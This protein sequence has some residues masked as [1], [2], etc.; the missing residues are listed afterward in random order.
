MST[1]GLG[2]VGLGPGQNAQDVTSFNF[3][4][5]QIYDDLIYTHG[6]HTL[7][8]GGSIEYDQ[9]NYDSPNQHSGVWNFGSLEDFYTGNATSFGAQI[10]GEP[11]ER[12]ARQRIFGVYAQDDIRLRRNLTVNLGLRYERATSPGEVD[13]KLADLRNITDPTSTIGSLYVPSSLN[14]SPRIGLAWDPFGNGKTSVRAAFGIYDALPLLYEMANRFNRGYPFYQQGLINWCGDAVS[15]PQNPCTPAPAGVF[16]KGGLAALQSVPSIVTVS[17]EHNPHRSYLTQWNLNVQRDLGHGLMAQLGYVG[18]RGTHLANGDYDINTYVPQMTAQGPFWDP[19]LPAQQPGKPCPSPTRNPAQALCFVNDNFAQIYITRWNSV[20]FY[21][22]LQASLTKRMSN[23][24]QVQANYTWSKSIDTNS[25]AFSSGGTLTGIA[26]PYPPTPKTDRGPSDF[27]VPQNFVVNALYHV[28]GFHTDSGIAHA[29]L[30]GW[31][32]GGIFTA[33]SGEPFSW[34]LTF[35]NPGSPNFG[36]G[37]GS[38]AFIGWVLGEKPDLVNTPACK[39]PY[40]L[41]KTLGAQNTASYID[42]ANR[43]EPDPAGGS[44]PVS[45]LE[46]VCFV[47]PGDT[48]ND[49]G[50]AG[51]IG[52]AGR[53]RAYTPPIVNVDF[54]LYKN[55]YAPRISEA[56]DVQF[57]AEFFNI[58]NHTNLG[59]PQ[60]A[61]M[62]L[63]PTGPN[64]GQAGYT[65]ATSRQIQLGVKI[66]F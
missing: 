47:G 52:D 3:N 36:T 54:S 26:N 45:M 12:G 35:D 53:N 50:R 19:T 10:P 66:I 6:M 38:H 14:F 33:S 51:Y 32:A 28:P 60:L 2:L 18:S 25:L 24:L 27:N 37:T 5:F 42:F 29:V 16:P 48:L 17:V 23:G 62:W 13:G 59:F 44:T 4:T 55:N 46:P 64:T 1:L 61:N 39:N 11:T 56:F 21:S 43:L 31:E 34:L 65:A 63:F 49:P 8:F 7:K 57:R 20:S 40:H 30:G 22:G 9:D 41:T 58:F 15:T